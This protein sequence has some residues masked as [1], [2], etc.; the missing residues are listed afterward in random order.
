VAITYTMRT[1]V[2]VHGSP[3]SWTAFERYMMDPVLLSKFRMVSIDRP[4]FG[5]SDYGD[6]LTLLENEKLIASM[7]DSISNSKSLYL[8]GHSLGGSVVPIIAAYHPDKITAIVI[9]AGALDPALEPREPWVHLFTK[10]PL[11]YLIPGAF[12]QANDEEWYFKSDVLKLKN[13]LSNIKCKVYSIH[14]Q[15]DGIVDV[16]N[17]AYIK[18]TFIDAQVSD[19]ILPGGGHFILWDHSAYIIKVLSDL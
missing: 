11:R 4:G 8:V 16:R 2:F 10:V 5:Y 1:I 17:V 6:A 14:A 7:I 12:R 18:K 13:K 9:L 19:T 3:G 15:N